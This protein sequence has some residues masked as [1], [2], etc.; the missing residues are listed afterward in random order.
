MV[1]PQSGCGGS[2]LKPDHDTHD[3]AGPA[4]GA[5]CVSVSEQRAVEGTVRL[6]TDEPVELPG[7]DHS[8]LRGRVVRAVNER[9]WLIPAVLLG[10]AVAFL[11][12]RRR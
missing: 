3:S 11:L 8:E 7:D 6:M 2:N 5:Q 9:P 4:T 12:L 1:P 10:G